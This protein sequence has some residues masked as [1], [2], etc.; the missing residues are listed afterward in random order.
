LNYN[1]TGLTA[2]TAYTFSVKAVDAAGNLSDSSNA[3]SV[4]TNA[5]DGPD[6]EA[7]TAP[8][9][10]HI[11]GTPT[12]S[13]LQLMWNA[14][15]DNVGVT[16]YRIY[17]GSTLLTTVSGTSTSYTVTGLS[18]STTYS[19][20]VYAF[21]AAGNQSTASTV[22]GTTAEASTAPAWAPNTA[23]TV[24]TLVTYNGSV[25]ECRQPHTSLNGW[26]PSNVPALWLLK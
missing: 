7:P 12:S 19:F 23:Y 14:S 24:G 5:N 16:G 8:G 11:M 18:P 13:S 9:G 26:E 4:T 10:L 2:N 15:T 3:L 21:D 25:Y 1:V 6:T 20:S 17:Q 22:N